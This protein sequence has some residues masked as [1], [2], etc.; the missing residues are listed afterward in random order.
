MP[1]IYANVTVNRLIEDWLAVKP[2]LLQPI[3][4]VNDGGYEIFDGPNGLSIRLSSD[5][6]LI[7]GRLCIDKSIGYTSASRNRTCD[8]FHVRNKLP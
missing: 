4:L 6:Q 7:S 2:V 1:A 5:P 3:S 8:L